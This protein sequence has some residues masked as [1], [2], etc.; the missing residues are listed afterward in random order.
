MYFR[1]QRYCAHLRY[2]GIWPVVIKNPAN[3]ICGTKSN[4][5]TS[6]LVLGL[7]VKETSNTAMEEE[8]IPSA[9]KIA[10]M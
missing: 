2:T 5:P 7:V 8:V 4:G 1:E 10:D 6:W 3:R 9:A